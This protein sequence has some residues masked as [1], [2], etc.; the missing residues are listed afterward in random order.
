[1]KNPKRTISASGVLGLLQIVNEIS[2]IRVWKPLPSIRV[3]KTLRETPMRTIY[4][5]V[6]LGCYK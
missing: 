5:T 1:M 2:F 4:A 6:G 3:L